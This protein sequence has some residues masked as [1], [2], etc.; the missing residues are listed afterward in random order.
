MKIIREISS[1]WILNLHSRFKISNQKNVD[2]NND[3]YC[4]PNTQSEYYCDEN[5]WFV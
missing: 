3:N 4:D 5:G 2:D 1:S